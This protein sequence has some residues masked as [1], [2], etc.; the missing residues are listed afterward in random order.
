MQNK[1]I[2]KNCFE[3]ITHFTKFRSKQLVMRNIFTVMY[4]CVADT[5]ARTLYQ[6]Q[7]TGP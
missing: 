7:L 5:G 3:F 6:L 2:S 1:D 4:L